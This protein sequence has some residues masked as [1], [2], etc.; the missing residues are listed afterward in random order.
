MHMKSHHHQLREYISG[1]A[2]IPIAPANTNDAL[3]MFHDHYPAHEQWRLLVDGI[4]YTKLPDSIEQ[5]LKRL[6]PRDEQGWIAYEKREPGSIKAFL[7]SWQHCLHLLQSQSIR[8]PLTKEFIINLHAK[9]SN[10]VQG[11]YFKKDNFRGYKDNEHYSLLSQLLYRYTKKGVENLWQFCLFNKSSDNMLK[12]GTLPT[13]QTQQKSKIRELKENKQYGAA[14]WLTIKESSVTYYPPSELSDYPF[15]PIDIASLTQNVIDDYNKNIMIAKTGDAKLIIIGK[16]IEALERI[17]PFI[18]GNGRTFV[19]LLM[20]YLL[21]QE[22]FPPATLFEPNVFDAYDDG[23]GET[24]LKVI[25]KGIENTLKIYSGKQNLFDFSLPNDKALSDRMNDIISE[26]NTQAA[27]YQAED[28][29]VQIQ[30]GK[31]G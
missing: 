14:A 7:S 8:T 15:D 20:N 4:L 10:G 31:L 29:P 19:N 2:N 17:H 6:Y 13:G 3:R 30:C 9:V 21:L 23:S 22:G 5:K 27:S 12:F 18:D 1:P 25:K 24:L 26:A 28:K 11:K 16:T